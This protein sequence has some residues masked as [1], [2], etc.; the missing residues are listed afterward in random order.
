[1]DRLSQPFRSGIMGLVIGFGSVLPERKRIS[2]SLDS[3]SPVTQ[4]LHGHANSEQQA[5]P[6]VYIAPLN[7]D[8]RR[9]LGAR[10]TT[11][12][13]EQLG[14]DQNTVT[15]RINETLAKIALRNQ[16][17]KMPVN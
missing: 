2:D 3:R 13:I 8:L 7:R 10:S 4:A 6:T 1:M 9:A 12:A 16:L 14:N 11:E 15:D 5:P 17:Y